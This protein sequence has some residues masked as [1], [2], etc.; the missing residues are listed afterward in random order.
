MSHDHGYRYAVRM[1]SKDGITSTTGWAEELEQARGMAKVL[2][3]NP[4]VAETWLEDRIGTPL[5]TAAIKCP[6]VEVE[7]I[8][9]GPLRH[10][11]APAP[12]V[13]MCN[14]RDRLFVATTDG[15][16]ELVGENFK[17]LE[18]IEGLDVAGDAS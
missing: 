18:L 16:Y 12:I 7:P 1:R 11:P 3:E 15:V 13:S 4:D 17:R 8:K 9:P 6:R 5:H 14:F 10:I 2:A